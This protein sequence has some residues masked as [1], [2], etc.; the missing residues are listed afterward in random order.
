MP[1]HYLA[2]IKAHYLVA[3]ISDSVGTVKRMGQV[4]SYKSKQ[5]VGKHRSSG[6]FKGLKKL[7]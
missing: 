6:E 4:C 3:T 5:Y 2:H 1:A 7:L